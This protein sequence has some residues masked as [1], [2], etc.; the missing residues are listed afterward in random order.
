MPD[1]LPNKD[2]PPEHVGTSVNAIDSPGLQLDRVKELQRQD[3]SLQDLINHFETGEIPEDSIS[4]RRLMATN[5]DYL[6]EE[7]ILYHLDKGRAR[8]RN[9][10]RIQLVIPRSLKDEVMLSLHEEITSGHLAFQRTY[11]KIKERYFWKGMYSEI[12]KWC[13][14]CVDCATKKTPRN[15]GKAPLQPIPVEGPFDRVAV[16]VLGPFPTSDRGNKY[17]VVFTD[18]FTKWPEAFAVKNADAPTTAK[19][20]VEEILCRHSAPTI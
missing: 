5:N 15:L 13:A 9:V 3:P 2:S 19:L 10:V 14:S 6:L 16:D 18:Y 11:L 12:E 8:S 20:F 4:A 7:G 17:V 1:L